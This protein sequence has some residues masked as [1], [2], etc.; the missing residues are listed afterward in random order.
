MWI[1]ELF[2]LFFILGMFA[3]FLVFMG[4]VQ[5]VQTIFGFLLFIFLMPFVMIGTLF[6]AFIRKLR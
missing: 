2:S 1:I 4:A 5:L 6:G 3:L